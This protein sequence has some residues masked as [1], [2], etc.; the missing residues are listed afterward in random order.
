MSTLHNLISGI[1]ALFRKEEREQEMNE[2][3]RSFQEASAEEKIRHGLTSDQARRAAR[4]EM[5]SIET[6]KHK[7]HAATWEST[8]ESIAHDIRF[9][10]R[11]LAKSPGF[12]AVAILSL[13][14]GIGGNTAIFTLIH[15]VL[16]RNLPV[17]D[18]QQLVTF[19]NSEGSGVI[20]GVDLGLYGL[21]PWYFARQLQA[22]PGPFQGIASYGSFSQKVSVRLPTA[23]KRSEEHTS[24][25]QS[26]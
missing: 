12:T 1:R 17:R 20:G 2:E 16:L 5:G 26:Q 13:A 8:A 4:I 19:G 3:L 9:S 11:S 6:V 21:F 24:E 25:L 22:D 10:F 14:L 23:A 18:P 15:Q 7:V